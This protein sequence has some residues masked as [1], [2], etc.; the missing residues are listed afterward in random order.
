MLFFN[1]AGTI[2]IRRKYNFMHDVKTPS[3]RRTDGTE[4]E[5]NDA[6]SAVEVPSMPGVTII[7]PLKGI[8]VDLYGNL[9]SAFE[10][11]YDGPIENIFSVASGD[12]PAVPVVEGLLR[13]YPNVDAKLIIGMCIWCFACLSAFIDEYDLRRN[14]IELGDDDVSFN[15]K[16]NN[17]VIPYSEARH[18]IIWILDSNVHVVPTTLQSSVSLLLD[19][20]TIGLVHHLPIAQSPTSKGSH[21]EHAFLNISHAKMYS[22]INHFSIAP[23]VVGK[24]TLFR[25]F[26]LDTALSGGFADLG[27][28][29]S[30]DNA[31]GLAIK[32]L[33]LRHAV[34]EVFVTQT[35]GDMSLKAFFSRRARWI[36]VRSNEVL[37]PTLIEPFSESIV[38]GLAFSWALNGLF[39]IPATTTLPIHFLFWLLCDWNIARTFDPEFVSQYFGTFWKAWLARELTTFA[40]WCWAVSGRTVDWRGTKYVL[41]R[42]GPPV[43]KS[44]VGGGTK[45]V[46]KGS[47]RSVSMTTS[48]GATVR[49][50]YPTVPIKR[51]RSMLSLRD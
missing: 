46:G 8:E 28:T 7:R 11:H 21:L 48:D 26:Q 44:D 5:D 41:R 39:S 14:L 20:P 50:K 31:L 33:G 6:D 27:K 4:D 49:L 43:R 12:D 36:R 22:V 18:D 9:V 42:D 23:C 15:P 47:L 24:S 3:Y 16:V 45:V 37:L 38:S 29:M 13:E 25:K 32:S 1:S 40:L 51:H 17:M 10:Q 19:D 34:G 30:E 2:V 35:L